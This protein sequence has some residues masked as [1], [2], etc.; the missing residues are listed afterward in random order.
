VMVLYDDS[1]SEVT[2]GTMYT[3]GR[4]PRH[5][6]Q[7]RNKLHAMT[8]YI[9][10]ETHELD[11]LIKQLTEYRKGFPAADSS[12]EKPVKSQ[13]LSVGD[14]VLVV[15]P[16]SIYHGKTGIVD[17]IEEDEADYPGIRVLFAGATSNRNRYFNFYK[18]E[19]VPTTMKHDWQI[20]DNQWH[21]MECTRCRLSISIGDFAMW[22][23]N[24]N[25]DCPGNPEEV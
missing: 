5:T 20:T 23:Q 15:D 2:I 8:S 21:N 4:G 19:V 12:I 3:V 25:K 10:L 17:N 6:L 11:H 9:N 16:E 14:T 22:N 7:V 18:E 13:G 1:M 24:V